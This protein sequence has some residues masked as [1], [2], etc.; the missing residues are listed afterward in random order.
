[1]RWMSLAVFTLLF[2]MSINILNSIDVFSN[3]MQINVN[4]VTQS[5]RN[6]Y[7]EKG[8]S[9]TLVQKIPVLGN[10]YQFFANLLNIVKL[11]GSAFYD[12]TIRLPQ[13]LSILGVPKQLITFLTAIVYIIYTLGLIE[14]LRGMEVI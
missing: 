3:Q 12:S 5:F 4:N 10:V 8:Q 13:F 14:F 6:V 7:N 11:L 2:F 9:Y 1:M